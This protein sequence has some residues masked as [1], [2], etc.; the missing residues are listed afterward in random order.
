[1]FFRTTLLAALIGL[2]TAS[3]AELVS[4]RATYRLEPAD[5]VTNGQQV[6]TG[7]E[8]ISQIEFRRTCAG[9]VTNGQSRSTISTAVGQSVVSE[10]RTSALESLDGLQLRF[11][12]QERLNGNVVE[13][14]EGNARLDAPGGTGYAEFTRPERSRIELP[15]GTLFPQAH[16]RAELEHARRGNR[17]F[18]AYLFDG[19]KTRVE[20]LSAILLSAASPQTVE[21]FDVLSALPSWRI[22]ESYFAS[23][24]DTTPRTE[25]S[26]RFWANGVVGDAE[27]R[28]EGLSLRQKLISLEILPDEGC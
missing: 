24:T 27:L 15:A 20:R 21:R 19:G 14:F 8:G 26:T 4:Y 12:R 6:I 25:I 13:S 5:R 11:S 23:E 16:T 1:M 3:A 28:M 7:F 10:S 22:T 2:N 17:V 9:W 18:D